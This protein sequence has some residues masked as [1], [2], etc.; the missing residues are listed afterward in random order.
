[1]LFANAVP[2]A[3]AVF[4]LHGRGRSSPSAGQSHAAQLLPTDPDGVYSLTLAN[5]VV[6]SAIRIEVAGTG[7]LVEQ[8]T[9][10]ASSEAFSIP[11]YAG[12]SALNNLRTKVR[13]G[14]ASPFYQPWE[15]LAA[16]F[17][18][19]ASIFVSQIPDE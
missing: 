7:A 8:R 17:D 3:A 10:A 9:A 2:S 16:A 13:K 1:M 18:G 15:T 12:A 11:A 5:L 4:Q 14:S 6:G 19:A